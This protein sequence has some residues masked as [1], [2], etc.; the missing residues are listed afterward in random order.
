MDRAEYL[1]DAIDDLRE[2]ASLLL[3]K[4]VHNNLSR[5]GDSQVD[6]VYNKWKELVEEEGL[7]L[8][9]HEERDAERRRRRLRNELVEIRSIATE[10]R[11]SL[12][13][14]QLDTVSHFVA[15]QLQSH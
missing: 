7:R 6:K 11:A 5:P 8:Q 4:G 1:T 13:E 9:E 12:E 10:V 2:L 3:C 14:E 15:A